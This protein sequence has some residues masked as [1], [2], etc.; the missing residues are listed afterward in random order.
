MQIVDAQ[1][2]IWSAGKPTNATHRRVP[3]DWLGW[4][5]GSS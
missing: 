1:I 5:R 3:V 2:H 4:K